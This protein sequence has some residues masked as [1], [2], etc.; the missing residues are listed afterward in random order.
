MFI[1]HI[2][3][4]QRTLAAIL[5]ILLYSNKNY[6]YAFFF[7]AMLCK[8]GHCLSKSSSQ[9][10]LLSVFTS[11]YWE[12]KSHI[13]HKWGFVVF[14]SKNNFCIIN[15]IKLVWFYSLYRNYNFFSKN[16]IFLYILKIFFTML[17]LKYF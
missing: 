13:L 14:Y 6:N 4:L 10:M 15:K 16:V 12:N 2:T 7:F 1:M 11:W 9:L 17:H 3:I 8:S 5:I